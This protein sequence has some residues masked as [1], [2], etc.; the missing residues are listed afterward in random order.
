MVE[1]FNPPK[2][3]NPKFL[4][5]TP[6]F[7]GPAVQF[8]PGE[9]TQTPAGW[10]ADQLR[11]G[12]FCVILTNPLPVLPAIIREFWGGILD[13]EGSQPR[14]SPP[15]GEPSVAAR[16]ITDCL[17]QGDSDAAAFKSRLNRSLSAN[18]AVNS[19]CD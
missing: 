17:R 18:D 11:S 4:R 7:T 10:R 2:L 9:S 13:D 3:H 19:G 6:E 5:K 1:N 15:R 14:W 16:L 8:R 12:R